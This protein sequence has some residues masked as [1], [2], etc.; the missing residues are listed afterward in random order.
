LNNANPLNE[1]DP[2]FV[3]ELL[4]RGLLDGYLVRHHDTAPRAYV[5]TAF[6]RLMSRI[7]RTLGTEARDVIVSEAES[8]DSVVACQLIETAREEVDPEPVKAFLDQIMGKHRGLP[9]ATVNDILDTGRK[10]G[11]KK[12]KPRVRVSLDMM[13]MES[14]EE[15]NA[16]AL[17]VEEKPCSDTFDLADLPPSWLA[18]IRKMRKRGDRMTL[19]N[20]AKELDISRQY[21]HHLRS[22]QRS[23]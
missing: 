19:T 17:A 15:E 1:I 2:E 6:Q 16:D 8:V 23:A 20:L 12:R 7:A 4:Q 5:E 22:R 21:L 11:A 3:A 18:A 14:F 13:E 10:Q 9:R